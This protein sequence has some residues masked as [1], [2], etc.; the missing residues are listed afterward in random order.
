MEL[1]RPFRTFA[2]DLQPD[3][4]TPYPMICRPF[5]DFFTRTAAW[6]AVPLVTEAHTRRRRGCPRI[7]QPLPL[8]AWKAVPNGL[9][10]TTF[11]DI[12]PSRQ[13][14]E[15]LYKYPAHPSLRSVCTGLLIVLPSRQFTTIEICHLPQN[16]YPTVNET[17][18]NLPLPYSQ[19]LLRQK[20]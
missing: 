13:K 19:T 20:A 18:C 12:L 14:K 10:Y 11:R 3:R 1:Y 7:N 5:Q 15:G 16:L 8:P 9:S 4:V 2:F 6:K 17:E